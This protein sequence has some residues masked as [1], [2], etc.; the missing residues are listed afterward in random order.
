MEKLREHIRHVMMWKFKNNKN[1][2]RA[3]KNFSN[4]YNQGVITDR[5]VQNWFTKIHSGDIS[6]RDEPWQKRS[7]DLDGDALRKLVEYNPRKKYPRISTWPQHTPIN[8]MP[9]L[10]KHKKSELAGC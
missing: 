10:E 1:V 2:P 5:Q 3:A 7:S 6:L 4:I 9:P 8:N